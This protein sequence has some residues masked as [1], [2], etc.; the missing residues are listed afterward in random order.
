M[1][2]SHKSLQFISKIASSLSINRAIVYKQYMGFWN[3]L[4]E[5]KMEL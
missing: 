4:A 2:L 5:R 3:K 1:G